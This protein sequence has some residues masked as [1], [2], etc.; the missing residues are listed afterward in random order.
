M[1][2]SIKRLLT[3]IILLDILIGIILIFANQVNNDNTDNSY[4]EMN[5]LTQSNNNLSKNFKN[6]FTD[7]T[8]DS[9]AFQVDKSFGNVRFGQSMIF[10]M[11]KDGV[12]NPFDINDSYTNIVEKSFIYGITIFLGLVHLFVILEIVYITYSRKY[13]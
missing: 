9:S 1:A 2:T 3:M 5:R 12:T 10:T 11:F 7:V 13:D 4:I 6:S 8:P